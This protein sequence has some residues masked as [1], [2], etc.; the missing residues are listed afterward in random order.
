MKNSLLISLCLSLFI[1]CGSS[2]DASMTASAGNNQLFDKEKVSR[3]Q[4]LI[5]VKQSEITGIMI[6]KYTGNEWRGSLVNEFGVKAFDFILSERKS[7]LQNTIPFLDKWYI[8]RTIASDLSFLF[9]DASQGKK[10]K[11]KSWERRTDGMFVLRN[12][13]R[14]IEYLF[15]PI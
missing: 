14:H 4:V 5:K 9:W 11:G 10:V 2:R 15:Q 7:R 8:R 3:Y 13:K 6:L 12:E 1:S